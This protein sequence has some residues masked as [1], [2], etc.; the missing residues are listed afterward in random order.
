MSEVNSQSEAASFESII[1]KDGVLVYTCKGFSMM[2]MLRQ[3]RDLVVISK[4]AEP[5]KK[6]DVILFK[7]NG[8]YILHRIVRV[9]EDSVDTAG[10]HNWWKEHNVRTDE[11]KGILTAFVRDGKEIRCDDP[12]YQRY[13]RLWEKTFYLRAAFLYGR[14]ASRKT[15]S[16][17]IRRFRK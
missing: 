15:V 5:L 3:H 6:N 11:I 10:D 4:I 13:V 8:K 9:R 7:R 16:R 17:I 2:P 1:E 14:A 12:D